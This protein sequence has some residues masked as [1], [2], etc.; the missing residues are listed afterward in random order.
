MRAYVTLRSPDG[1]VYAL[2]HGDVIGRLWS[3]AMPVD[4]ARVSEAHA[5]VS[6]RGEALKLLS[7]R[8]LFS[9]GRRPMREL[10]LA[11]GQQITLARGVVIEVVSVELPE[12]VLALE[13]EG[14]PTQ[15]LTR[16]CSLLGGEAPALVSG[17]HQGAE[18][19]IWNMGS[20]WRIRTPTQDSAL[21]EPGG[22]WILGGRP[23]RAVEVS[24]TSAAGGDTVQRSA[25]QAPLRIVTRFDTVHF[26]REGQPAVAISGIPAR[27]VSELAAVGA[28]ISWAAVAAEVW[29]DMDRLTLRRRWDVNLSRLRSKLQK[30]RL[31]GD[32]IRAD[33]S[34]NFELLL[35][36]SD[37]LE[38]Q[39]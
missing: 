28:P 33:G 5:M 18:A 29:K 36:P 10:T 17:Y 2:S 25:I 22:V 14:V 24:L 38:V 35:Y 12:T 11:A 21:L 3:A 15:V 31:R 23:Y 1:E 37:R 30:A 32:L 16:V 19:L 6:L 26:H 27:I 7:L 39:D 20:E 8:G 4:D 34:G 9:T 13:G